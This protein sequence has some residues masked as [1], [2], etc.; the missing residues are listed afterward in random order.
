[1]EKAWDRNTI[2]SDYLLLPRLHL[3]LLVFP[4]AAAVGQ[5]TVTAVG[6]IGGHTG[7]PPRVVVLRGAA[8]ELSLHRG[9]LSEALQ[10][11][12]VVHA[13]MAGRKERGRRGR[14]LGCV[15]T[16]SAVACAQSISR[17]RGG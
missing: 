6:R 4:L 3:F 14:S 12:S 15:N 13:L 2:D 5:D 10:V 17:G 7:A 1:M 16:M 11:H 9:D 8:L